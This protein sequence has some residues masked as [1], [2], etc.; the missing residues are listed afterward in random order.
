MPASP[1]PTCT[2]IRTPSSRASS[3]S[4]F[5]TSG[6]VNS[7]PRGASASVSS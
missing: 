6:V 4:C 7:G 1:T 2:L 3:Q 5:E